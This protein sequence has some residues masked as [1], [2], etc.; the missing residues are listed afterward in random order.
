MKPML[1]A[2]L[3]MLLG[4]GGLAAAQ[5]SPFPDPGLRNPKLRFGTG[6]VV[7]NQAGISPVLP[8]MP[9]P[10]SAW[11]VVQ[12]HHQV[13]LLPQDLRPGSASLRDARFG[14]PQYAVDA[15]DGSL[16]LYI[17]PRKTT[18]NYVYELGE[19][20]GIVMN[21][22]GTSLFLSAKALP[23]VPRWDRGLTLDLEARVVGASIRYDTPE[24][25]ASGAVLGNAEIGVTSAYRGPGPAMTLFYQMPLA[26]SR[27]HRQ[28]YA[29]C[30]IRP[31]GNRV[32][33]IGKP[34]QD[35][36]PLAFAP[37]AGPLRPIH[38]DL[39]AQLQ[40]ALQQQIPC[41]HAG[42]GEREMFG[43]TGAAADPAN[44]TVGA[45]YIGTEIENQDERPNATTHDPQGDVTLAIQ[46]SNLR[47]GADH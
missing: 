37:D 20:N 25:E 28:R 17:F 46:L 7:D 47:V 42:T 5:T 35:G 39:S 11:Y 4:A 32:I 29:S 12:W 16:H 18:G 36:V 21:G 1:A 45:L 40:A 34:P 14:V 24:A 22:G 27:R 26:S 31:N 2:S 30:T 6:E 23:P 44:W 38:E 15:P 19:H 41:T 8:D 43:F 13:K 10:P 33:L 9:G 3:A